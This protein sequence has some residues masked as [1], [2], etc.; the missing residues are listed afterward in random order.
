MTE[1]SGI[2]HDLDE[3]EYHARPELSST[4]ARLILDAPA[5]YRWK[6]DNPPLIAP[7]KK[8]DIGTAIHTRVL[9]VGEPVS[10]IPDEVLA[11]N[12]AATTK[13]AK[14]F[15]AD[16]RANGL[17]PLKQDEYDGTVAAAESVLAH[18][19]ARALFDQPGAAEVSVFAEVDGVPV[20][21][22][23]DYLPE[24]GERRRVAVDLKSTVDASVNA[25][26]KSVA[27]FGYDVQRGFYLDALEA[28]TGPM[29]HGLEPELVFLAVEKEPPYLVAVHQLAQQWAQMGHVKARRAREVFAACTAS[30]VWPGHPNEIQLLTAPVW[31]TIRF[32]ETYQ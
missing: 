30:G 21:A 26:E 4:E 2:V 12:G 18:P 13:A 11:A 15:I 10:V 16:A 23:F 1:Y 29:P 22:R 31:E 7:S 3:I 24:Q 28:V 20:R 14:E 9:G 5:R 32:E 8:F 27:N 17:V 6:K 19:T 25:F